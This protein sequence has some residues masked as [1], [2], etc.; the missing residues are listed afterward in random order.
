MIT[1]S[2]KKIL[3]E[4]FRLINSEGI[5]FAT[6]FYARLFERNP[7]LQIMFRSKMSEQ[8]AKFIGMLSLIIQ[9]MNNPI[10]IM[11]IVLEMGESHK[12]YGVLP[13][14]WY[15]V[16]EVFISVADEKLPEHCDDETRSAWRTAFGFMSEIMEA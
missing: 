8:Y 14:H 10:E 6:L 12:H 9:G 2:Q 4:Q 3:D 13:H 7:E 11:P 5:V 15:I 16:Q 1:E